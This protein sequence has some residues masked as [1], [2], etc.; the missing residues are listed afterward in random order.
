MKRDLFGISVT[1][2]GIHFRYTGQEI[3]LEPKGQE[4]ILLSINCSMSSTGYLHK[5]QLEG[6]LEGLRYMERIAETKRFKQVTEKK[7]RDL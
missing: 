6:L 3:P 1:S 5:D 7:I 4:I 2:K